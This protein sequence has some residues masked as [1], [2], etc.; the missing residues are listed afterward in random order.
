MLVLIILLL[1]QTFSP[2]QN[3]HGQRSFADCGVNVSHLSE[4]KVARSDWYC[5]GCRRPGWQAEIGLNATHLLDADVRVW[6]ETLLGRVTGPPP[7]AAA[8]LLLATTTLLVAAILASPGTRTPRSPTPW[9]YTS[10]SRPTC[11]SP[12]GDALIQLTNVDEIL[13]GWCSSMP[14]G[15]EACTTSMLG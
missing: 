4:Q 3:Q 5:K 9:P 6:V 11:S 7:P 10:R 2:S 13:S 14:L 12:R 1:N 8:T 15:V